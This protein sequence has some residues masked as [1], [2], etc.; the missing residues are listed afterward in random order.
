MS[1]THTRVTASIDWGKKRKEKKRKEA[2]NHI[3]ITT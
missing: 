1:A 3:H 2:E